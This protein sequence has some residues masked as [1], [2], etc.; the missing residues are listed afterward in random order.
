[1]LIFQL[2]EIQS[3]WN[4]KCDNKKLVFAMDGQ[5]ISKINEFLN[6]LFMFYIELQRICV[7]SS[8]F[9]ILIFDILFFVF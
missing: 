6:F 9:S 7:T 5:V 8:L 1:M 3:A 4:I 2:S